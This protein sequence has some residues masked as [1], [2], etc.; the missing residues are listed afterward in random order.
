MRVSLKFLEFPVF[1]A[2]K[3]VG[4]VFLCGGV[5]GARCIHHPRLLLIWVRI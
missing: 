2:S 5:V 1:D 3:L 4:F